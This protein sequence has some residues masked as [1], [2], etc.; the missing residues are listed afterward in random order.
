[1]NYSLLDSSVHG[2]LQARILECIVI[3]FSWV[4][5]EFFTSWATKEAL[6]LKKKDSDRAITP[7][8]EAV[9]SLHTWCQK[10]PQD[11]R[12]CATFT[13]NPHWNRAA[14]CKKQSCIYAHGVALVISNSLQPC[15]LWPARLPCQEFLQAR[16]LEWV[17][18]P[19]YISCCP[20]LQLP[21][22]PR[23]A[24]APA[25]QAAAPLP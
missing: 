25:I 13:L 14:T 2:I 1:M 7:V 5:G 11:P 17:A 3:P 23:A 15:G 21:W 6:R 19:F 16:I 18:I 24:R 4:A 9:Q 10:D 22:V 12:S 8:T 20:S